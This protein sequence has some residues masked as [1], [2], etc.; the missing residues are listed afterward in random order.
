MGSYWLSVKRQLR[1]LEKTDWN[2]LPAKKLTDWY[3]AV[4][5]LKYGQSSDEALYGKKITLPEVGMTVRL[6]KEDDL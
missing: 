5:N 1:R 2:R 3:E 4:D 6:M